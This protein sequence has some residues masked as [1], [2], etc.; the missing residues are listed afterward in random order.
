MSAG[1]TALRAAELAA[2]FPRAS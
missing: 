1:I 2:S